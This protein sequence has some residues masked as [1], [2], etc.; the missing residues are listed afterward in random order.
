MRQI[1][2]M[3]LIVFSLSS[4]GS[5]KN[6]RVITTKSKT[7]KATRPVKRTQTVVRSATLELP[8]AKDI[9][10]NAEKYE[11]TRYKYGG[12]TK[13][14]MDCSGLIYT[15]FKEE[16]ITIPRVSHA[17]ATSGDWID[18]KEVQKGD[19]LF[20]ATKKNNRSVNH[21]GL[22]TAI[23][24]D[25]VEFIHATTSRGVITS[26]LKEKYWYFAFVQARR[27]L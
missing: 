8:L 10:K 1:A 2:L 16:N 26:K 14:G 4:C 24:D 22:V 21:V 12:T 11:G 17:M 20:F 5:A 9:I 23:K 6:R 18:L 13:K 25:D 19:L 27:V 7:T 3:L 15:A